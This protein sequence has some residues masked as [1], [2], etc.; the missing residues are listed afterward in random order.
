MQTLAYLRILNMQTLAYLNRCTCITPRAGHGIIKLHQPT[1]SLESHINLD[2][3][4]ELPLLV[5]LSYIYNIGVAGILPY[6]WIVPNKATS[7]SYCCVGIN[8]SFGTQLTYVDS[9]FTLNGECELSVICEYYS[10]D[11]G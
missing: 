4:N 3:R 8:K 2:T 11:T 7:S 5:S 10:L 9:L 6:M 1:L